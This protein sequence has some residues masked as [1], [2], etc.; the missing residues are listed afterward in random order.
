MV[1]GA[2][3]FSAFRSGEEFLVAQ[4]IHFVEDLPNEWQDQWLK[5][6]DDSTKPDGLSSLPS[7]HK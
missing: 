4:M 6:R 2:K 5:M 3:P 1:F 7:I